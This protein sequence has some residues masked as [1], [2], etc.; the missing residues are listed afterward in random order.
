MCAHDIVVSGV[1]EPVSNSGVRGVHEVLSEDLVCGIIL[2]DFL[3][4]P[5]WAISV[6]IRFPP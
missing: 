5:F 6:F 2:T 1:F 3:S 4:F